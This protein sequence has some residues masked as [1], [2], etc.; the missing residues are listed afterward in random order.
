MQTLTIKASSRQ[1]VGKKAAKAVR[2][3]GRVPGVIYGGDDT[4]HFTIPVNDLKPIVYTGDLYKVIVDVDG[5]T[6]DTILKDIQ[7]HPVTDVIEHID[8]QELV[9][10]RKLRT[11]IPIKITGT[12]P[13]VKN[14]GKLQQKLR[15]LRVRV[16]P[17]N[18]V[19]HVLVD[20][21][22][23]ELGSSVKVSDV[24]TG[25]IEV[26]TPS[27]NPVASVVVPRALRSAEDEAADAAAEALEGAEGEGEG[28]EAGAEAA[29]E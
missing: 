13:G 3:E 26:L 6:Y 2:S 28:G 4:V 27:S 17:A 15:T 23:L 9:A 7:F 14:G 8:F 16:T 22:N 29:A 18:I 25:D 24:V 12:S 10:G 1:D 21:S 11:E 5:S 20:I 19:D